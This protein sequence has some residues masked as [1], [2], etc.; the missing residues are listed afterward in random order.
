MGVSRL[1]MAALAAMAL[2]GCSNTVNY[3]GEPE[4]AAAP[5]SVASEA[6]AP[7]LL[8]PYYARLAR[9]MDIPAMSSPRVDPATTLTRIAIGSCNHHGR[10]Q[11]IW[12]VISG[13]NP[14]LFLAI[15]DNIY[16]D[17]GYQGE[18]DLGSFIKA[19]RQQASHPEF[20]A[21]RAATP[22]LA[23]WDDHDFGPNDSGGAF[24][25]KEWSETLFEAF[26]DVPQEARD[27]RG[28]H[29]AMTSGPDGQRVQIIMLDTRF[30]RSDLLSQPYQEQRPPLG[31]YLP[32]TS[33]D[34]E[35]LGAGQ[36]QW[37][38]DTLAEPADLR[39]LVSSIQ[40]LT[41]AHNF[42]KWGNMPREREKLYRMLSAREDSGLVLVSGDR[43]SG[44]I[45]R[46]APAALGENVWE[47]TTSS[48]N[49]AFVRDDAS[50]REPDPKRTTGMITPENFG[51]ID[52]DWGKRELVLRVLSDTGEDFASQRVSF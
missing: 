34:A 12:P 33:A 14:Q 52:I 35:L 8:R 13:M 26:W 3:Y 11:D 2:A 46:E 30:F 20:K 22:V 15:G 27:H 45:Y 41:D 49:L 51:L 29:H 21:F 19:Y 50:E 25:G 1:G 9:E 43:H 47:L 10:S 32:N 6:S 5:M 44:A 7:E 24:F 42:E 39:I 40:V 18:A 17:T 16:G 36:W 28:V 48:L 4:V 31:G 23:T 38:Q 37:L